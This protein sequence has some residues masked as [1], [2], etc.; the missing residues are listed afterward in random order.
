MLDGDG[1]YHLLLYSGGLDEQPALDMSVMD[2][3][4]SRWN[5]LRNQENKDGIKH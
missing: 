5:E 4:K 3:I 1:T 2:I